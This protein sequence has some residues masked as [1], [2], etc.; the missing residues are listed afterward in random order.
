MAPRKNPNTQSTSKKQKLSGSNI[1]SGT[2]RNPSEN[3]AEQT[4]P[5]ERIDEE[6]SEED[7]QK[8][9]DLENEDV[10]DQDKAPAKETK[11]NGS[12]KKKKTNKRS[13]SMETDYKIY[14]Y[15]I[16]KQVHPQV[17]IS[18]KAMVIANNFIN[19]IF[20]RVAREAQ[21]LVQ[22]HKSKSLF[23]REIQYATKL[24]LTGE[25]GKHAVLEGQKAIV[26]YGRN[27]PSKNK[28]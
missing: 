8:F 22:I 4:E 28:L 12:Q 15:R 5:I 11:G 18:A 9:S 20:E 16:L 21:Q 19:D 17:G 27:V 23:S 3:F 14:I 6:P 13:Q 2:N 7:Q 1:Q 25:L 26:E 10:I 24:I